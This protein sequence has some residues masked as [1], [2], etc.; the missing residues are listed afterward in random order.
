MGS[1]DARV[2]VDRDL[3]K[4]EEAIPASTC[5]TDLIK[6]ANQTHEVR[7]SCLRCCV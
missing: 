7:D 5:E 4:G 1:S 6:L 3:E 2:T